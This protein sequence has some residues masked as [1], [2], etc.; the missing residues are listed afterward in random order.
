MSNLAILD[1]FKKVRQGK[2]PLP[3]RIV[4]YGNAG[5]GKSSFGASLPKHI[6]IDTEGR[7]AHLD[8]N[9]WDKC[10]SLT[11]VQAYLSALQKE[12]HDYRTLVIDSLDWLESIVHEE[13]C[14]NN[15]ISSV[16]SIPYGKGY[17]EAY[18]IW[19][20][21]LTTLTMLRDRKKMMIVCTGHATIKKFE[22]PDTDSYDQYILNL[23]DKVAEKVTQWCDLLMFC[24][25]KT[26]IKEG[27]D[28]VKRGS[29]TGQR[30][31]YTKDNAAYKAKDSYKLPAELVVDDVKEL[32]PIINK[33]LKEYYGQSDAKHS[34][35]NTQT[36]RDN[37][38]KDKPVN[39]TKGGDR[40]T[41]EVKS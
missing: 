15:N 6:F 40:K 28:G 2:E 23:R 38:E 20:H 7:L 41:T 29:S 12:E 8:C 19:E 25:Y 10:N 21:I 24:N 26:R 14:K 13:V 37:R 30:I 11:E 18:T 17:G 34:N 22:S 27:S 31:F 3:P 9:R 36:N 35:D 16:A 39:D 32:W 1:P 5:L 4:V 33:H